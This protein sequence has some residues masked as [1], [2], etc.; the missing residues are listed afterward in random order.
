MFFLRL[1]PKNFSSY[2]C[3]FILKAENAGFYP[4][5]FNKL[6]GRKMLFKV[7]RCT[8]VSFMSDGSFR[9]KRVCEEA[10][11]LEQFNPVDVE[12]ESTPFKVNVHINFLCVLLGGYF[13]SLFWLIVYGLG[14]IQVPHLWYPWGWSR[15]FCVCYFH[16]FGHLFEYFSFMC[17]QFLL[18]RFLSSCLLLPIL[19]DSPRGLVPIFREYCF[20]SDGVF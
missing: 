13:H 15:Y 7:E 5:H 19:V 17:L 9:V 3:L 14:S 20:M 8:S 10:S 4:T 2:D 11:V 18:M 12:V 6:K 1:F 16:I